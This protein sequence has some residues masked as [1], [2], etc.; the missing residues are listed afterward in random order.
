L[1][2]LIDKTCTLATNRESARV[3]WSLQF[4]RAIRTKVDWAICDVAALIVVDAHRKIVS[5]HK[6][7]VVEVAV[8][9]ARQGELGKRGWWHPCASA[10]VT[11]E[12]TIAATIET[13][14]GSRV[15]AKVTVAA[16]LS[17]RS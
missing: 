2:I 15:A 13:G 12:T 3:E 9:V 4:I 10:R 14:I 17:C 7:N 6:G 11:F 8:S 16:T 1:W 5:V